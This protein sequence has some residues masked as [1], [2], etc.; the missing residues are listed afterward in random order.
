MYRK[1]RPSDITTILSDAVGLRPGAP[2]RGN[3]VTID[4]PD[5]S[6]PFSSNE[7]AERNQIRFRQ[8]G[9]EHRF[10]GLWRFGIPTMYQYFTFITAPYY[11]VLTDFLARQQDVQTRSGLVLTQ[12]DP[13]M[14][15]LWG[16]RFL[17]TDDTGD[18]GRQTASLPIGGGRPLRLIEL[19]A[20]NLGDYSPTS[21]R[22]VP[23]FRSGLELMHAPTFDGTMQVLTDRPIEGDLVKATNVRLVYETYG[24]HI[25]AESAGNSIL[26]LPPQFSRCWSAEGAGRATSVSGKSHAIGTAVFRTAGRSPDLPLR[27]ALRKWMPP[28]GC[29]RHRAHEYITG[30]DGSAPVV[31]P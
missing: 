27:P 12:I 13:K 4:P 30:A 1:I 31:T 28:R 2:F 16:V 26:V 25:E 11:V 17:I 29:G 9:N 18:V 14:L 15:R 10:I 21:V 3:V 23:D 6:K 19:D 22:V 5:D 7:M 24:F 20:P 8:T